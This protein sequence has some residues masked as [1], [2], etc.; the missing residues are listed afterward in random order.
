MTL[1]IVQLHP[2]TVYR[3]VLGVHW[4]GVEGYYVFLLLFQWKSI[5]RIFMAILFILKSTVF[6]DFVVLV[7]QLR[8]L[9]MFQPLDNLFEYWVEHVTFGFLY[10]IFWFSTKVFYKGFE[11]L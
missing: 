6:C 8:T 2:I 10:V 4:S 3:T 5:I 7:L 9:F 11:A 1:C